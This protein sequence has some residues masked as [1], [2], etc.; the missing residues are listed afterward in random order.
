MLLQGYTNG[1]QQASD[2][3]LEVRLL[4][5]GGIVTEEKPGSG[6]RRV[7]HSG[8]AMQIDGADLLA[9]AGGK[10]PPPLPPSSCGVR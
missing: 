8:W 6:I 3:L 2:G 4:P 7:Y 1:N 10:Q 9:V 5:G